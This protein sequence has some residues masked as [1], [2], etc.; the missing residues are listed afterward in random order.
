MAA[1]G[2]SA[3]SGY[4]QGSLSRRALLKVGGI[5][6]LGLSLPELI[7][8]AERSENRKS[9]AKSII[10]LH[11]FGGP[12]QFETFDM[13]PDAPEGVRGTFKPIRTK[14]SGI[15]VC[16]MLPRMAG[17]ADKFTLVRGVR[18]EMKNHNSAT[19]YSL[20]GHAP[21][22][23]DIRLRDTRDLFPAF[24]SVVDHLLPAKKG[25]PSFVAYPSVLR[26][27]SL[28]PGQHA[29]F[30]GK[31]NDPLLITQDPNS[32]DFRL[33]EL[34]LPASLSSERL[35]NRREI[36]KIIDQQ[37]EL[38]DFSA[39]ARG[40]DA[41]YEKALTMLTAPG[42]KKAFDLSSEPDALRERYGRTT[43]GQSCLLARR[44]VEA[45]VRFINVYFADRIGG[46]AA[47]GGWDTHGFNDKPMDPIL[48]N[49]LLPLTNQVVPSLLE[50]LDA[51]GLLDTTL[52][53]WMGEFG[54]SP[55]IN[56]QAGRDHWPQCYTIVLAGAGVKR[57][58]VHGVTDKLG[59][60][61]TSDSSRP[62]D[63]AATMFSL[64]GIDHKTEVFDPLNKPVP[65]TSG[66]PIAGV[67]D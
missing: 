50:D 47:T 39:K 56:A 62:E 10:F 52:V 14:V 53:V 43:Y 32:P 3:C 59:A 63:V 24:G 65:I 30:L 57:G 6:L 41:A 67:L 46:Q 49:Y 13:K 22:L 29:S 9:A 27:G 2:S 11:Q 26:D 58:Y 61:P 51:R 34:E 25:V 20:T 5:G 21:P 33:P 4:D 37:S 15:S 66:E 35:E 31:A 42:V 12:S 18:H 60:Y 45:G 44:L 16:E 19:Y 48:K 36:L 7:H 55:R 54:R 17:V 40:I 23:D 8:A 38:L 1:S 64:L 28:T